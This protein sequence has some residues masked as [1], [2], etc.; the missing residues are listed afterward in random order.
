MITKQFADSKDPQL[1]KF[2]A[3]TYK[4]LLMKYLGGR[5][6]SNKS[7]NP[8]FFGRVF[9]HCNSSLTKSLIKPLLKY[10][11]PSLKAARKDS[12]DSAGGKKSSPDGKKNRKMSEISGL[13]SVES[14]AQ[15][16]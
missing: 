6:T 4:E 10:L 9:E 7:L 11:L 13:D 5:A 16:P 1:V 3:F 2:V 8:Q 14:G 15:G 12:G